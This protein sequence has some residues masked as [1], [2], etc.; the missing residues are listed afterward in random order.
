MLRLISDRIKRY[1]A[2]IILVS[3]FL[4]RHKQSRNAILFILIMTALSPKTLAI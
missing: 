2:T 3:K 1:I 4:P